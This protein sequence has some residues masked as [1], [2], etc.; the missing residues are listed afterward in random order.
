MQ[1]VLRPTQNDI[2]HY[3]K[4]HDDSPPGRGSG[5]YAWGSGK[6]P[7]NKR[8]LKRNA[9]KN[10]MIE[11][12]Q[13]HKLDSLQAKKNAYELYRMSNESQK[14]EASYF[15]NAKSL[16][17]SGDKTLD[18]SKMEEAKA[19]KLYDKI[20]KKYGDDTLSE[21][22]KI[23][24]YNAKKAM[25][26]F[27]DGVKKL[28]T[29]IEF[30]RQS[31]N[32]SRNEVLLN[33]ADKFNQFDGNFLE[34]IQNDSKYDFYESPEFDK[35]FNKAYSEAYDETLKWYK[36]NEPEYLKNITKLENGKAPDF[37]EYHDFR[38]TLEGYHDEI[39]SKY[40]EDFNKK[41]KPTVL[42]EYEKYLN[43]PDEYWRNRGQS[44]G[45]NK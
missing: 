39:L 1:Y 10:K 13:S 29:E 7:G 35:A 12:Y 44:R 28:E 34:A 18:Y 37:T 27:N 17:K 25:D 38:K 23:S 24:E 40:E 42:K 26:T 8:S 6:E 3:G 9:K 5:R 4:G 2:L 30:E 32:R 36:A 41:T 14:G 16:R 19:N 20:M 22:N 21:S 33:R 11:K 31:V 45:T 43:N 15:K